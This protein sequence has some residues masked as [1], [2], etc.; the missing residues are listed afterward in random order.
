MDGNSLVMLLIPFNKGSPSS[1]GAEDSLT[2]KHSCEAS[3]AVFTALVSSR[4]SVPPSSGTSVS[5]IL[6]QDQLRTSAAKHT[7]A[8]FFTV[9]VLEKRGGQNPARPFRMNNQLL[10]VQDRTDHEAQITGVLIQ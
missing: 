4:E 2:R 9:C 6:A 3:M 7:K 10:L 1:P 8:D 5:E